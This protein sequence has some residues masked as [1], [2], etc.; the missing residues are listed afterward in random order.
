MIGPA[1]C[2]SRK[3]SS[4]SN[5]QVR[6]TGLPGYRIACDLYCGTPKRLHTEAIDPCKRKVST[7]LVCGSQKA[8]MQ[9]V[10]QASLRAILTLRR[11]MVHSLQGGWMQPTLK[12][13]AIVQGIWAGGLRSLA[14]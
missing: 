2:G 9:R 1:G 13:T 14:G 7:S 4:P 5:E 6:V 3:P 11:P 12:L 10:D 8:D